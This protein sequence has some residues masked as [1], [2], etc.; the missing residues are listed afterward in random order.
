MNRRP[1]LAAT[2]LAVVAAIV[3]AGCTAQRI[4]A[5][6]ELARQT[7]PFSI[8]RPDAIGRILVVGDSTAAGT[9][10]SSPAR[11]LP[12]QLAE[13]LPRVTIHN[14]SVVGARFDDVSRQIPAST[15][16]DVVVVLAGG[17]DVIALTSKPALRESVER[18]TAQAAAIAPLVILMPSGNVGNA[19]FFFPPWSWVMTARAKT[20]HEVVRE[21]AQQHGATYVNL[22]KPKSLDPF[23]RDPARYH[24]ADG[25]HPSDAGYAQWLEELLSQSV[26]RARLGGHGNAWRSRDIPSTMSR[27]SIAP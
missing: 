15:T 3:A 10:A 22:F 1:S 4:S 20:L 5:S 26:L 6:R 8:E 27:S 18:V 23:A 2:S 12:G 24:A 19:P 14:R 9:G 7:D 11:S 25:L 16:Y 21:A 17:N 13:A